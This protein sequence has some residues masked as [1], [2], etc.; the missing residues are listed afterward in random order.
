MRNI[1]ALVAAALTLF[2]CDRVQ[3]GEQSAYLILQDEAGSNHKFL[4]MEKISVKDCA[5]L[6]L[7]EV[8]AY[9]E[10]SYQFWANADLTYGGFKAGNEDWSRYTIV[11]SIC[12]AEPQ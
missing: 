9:E 6:I 11:G 8:S 12:R 2:G 3:P 4:L 5:A 1:A 7:D 10:K